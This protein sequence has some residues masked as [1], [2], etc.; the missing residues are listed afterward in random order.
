M[1]PHVLNELRKVMRRLEAADNA[2]AMAADIIRQIGTGLVW[3]TTVSVS[4]RFA[5]E[6]DPETWR[7]EIPPSLVKV[8]IPAAMAALEQTAR[9]E[10]SADEARVV[11]L[12]GEHRGNL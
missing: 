8:I 9:T 7:I 3:E 4:M 1:E 10:V 12:V 2:A 6:D 11:E 5:G